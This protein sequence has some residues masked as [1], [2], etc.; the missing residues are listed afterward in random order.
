MR[1]GT[2]FLNIEI[3]KSP[4]GQTAGFPTSNTD[5]ILRNTLSIAKEQLQ[6]SITHK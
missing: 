6:I 3:S 5:S 4:S 2:S 1:S